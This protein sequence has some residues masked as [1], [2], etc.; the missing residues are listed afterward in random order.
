[1]KHCLNCEASFDGENWQC[2]DCKWQPAS[3]NGLRVFAPDIATADDMYRASN[4]D[5]LFTL[6]SG[7]FWFEARNSIILWA[8][9][10]FAPQAANLLEIGCGTGFVL[11]AVGQRFP[12]MS[13][14]ASDLFVEGL[15][16]AEQRVSGAEFFQLDARR[17]PFR[18][19]FDVIGLF[20]VIEHISDDN[21]VLG[22]VRKAVRP[23]GVV[24]LTVPQHPYLWSAHDEQA[25][26]Q[27]RYRRGELERKA[28]DVGFDVL[29]TTSFVTLLLPL[30]MASRARHRQATQSHQEFNIGKT[31]N[32]FLRKVM[33][34][35]LAIIRLGASLPVGGSRLV[36][37][38][39]S[40]ES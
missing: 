3:V 27:R 15:K 36:V 18:D 7:N 14:A 12:Q 23:G 8:L 33:R 5:L 37:L 40:H 31:V 10:K 32:N 16:F 24:V 4:F 9:R 20:D 17:L 34:V 38:R 25:R 6:E 30:M 19:H 29:Y 28:Q 39:R 22:E 26:H 2:P 1:M 35:E 11:Q 13:L 21:K